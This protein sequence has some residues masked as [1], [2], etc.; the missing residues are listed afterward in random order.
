MSIAVPASTTYVPGTQTGQVLVSQ[1]MSFFQ[2]TG[3]DA[4]GTALAG[5]NSGIS[6]INSKTWKKIYGS[7]D[8]TFVAGTSEYAV[9]SNFKDP[10]R[11][12]LLDSSSNRVGRVDHMTNADMYDE[13][14][15]ETTAGEPT[16][17]TVNY[18][19]RKVDLDSDPT[20]AWVTNYPTGRLFYHKR[21]AKLTPGGSTGLPPEFDEFLVA[22]GALWM[23]KVRDPRRV[24]DMATESRERWSMLLR[25]DTNINTDFA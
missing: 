6:M 11:L 2:A 9:P 16:F 12:I 13:F 23:A 19:T 15:V 21:I 1:I 8:I 3:S 10:I 14:Q 20:S 18:S 22:R 24:S 7:T 5:L 25:D 4:E 17:Y